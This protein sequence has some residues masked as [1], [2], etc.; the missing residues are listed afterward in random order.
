MSSP[1]ME[2]AAPVGKQ[3]SSKAPFA[4]TT[5]AKHRGRTWSVMQVCIVGFCLCVTVLCVSALWEGKTDGRDLSRR[6]VG[7]TVLTTLTTGYGAYWL[8]QQSV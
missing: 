1:T 5:N 8:A 7:I 4:P 3:E 2:V 6:E